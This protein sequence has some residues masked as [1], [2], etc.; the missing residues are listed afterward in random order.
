MKRILSCM[1][2]RQH[3]NEWLCSACAAQN[4]KRKGGGATFCTI[5]WLEAFQ[6]GCYQWKCHTVRLQLIAHQCI[7]LHCRVNNVQLGGRGGGAS[8]GSR[9]INDLSNPSI[10]NSLLCR[11]LKILRKQLVNTQLGSS[12]QRTKVIR[13]LDLAI[14]QIY[15]V[16][17]QK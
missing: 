11:V 5:M 3:I 13:E 8:A 17:L 10:L 15:L 7:A 4:T 14:V 6:S 9:G 1:I 16:F 2:A 12:L